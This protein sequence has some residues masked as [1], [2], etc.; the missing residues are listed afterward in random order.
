VK[1]CYD[2]S[3]FKKKGHNYV[4][5]SGSHCSD[6]EEYYILECDYMKPGRLPVFQRNV[7]PPFTGYLLVVCSAYSLILTIRALYSSKT[8][9]MCETT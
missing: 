3:S 6:Y 9:V 2:S 4:R 8:L 7:L 5:F 1:I